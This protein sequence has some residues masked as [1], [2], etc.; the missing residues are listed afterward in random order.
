MNPTIKFLIRA[1]AGLVGGYFL[2]RIFLKSQSFGWWIALSALL[3]VLAYVLEGARK[4][5]KK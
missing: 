4:E 2:A 3:V 5:K 1:A